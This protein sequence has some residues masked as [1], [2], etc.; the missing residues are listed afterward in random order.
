M[1][2]YVPHNMPPPPAEE[3]EDQ[4]GAGCCSAILLVAGVGPIGAGKLHL[5]FLL[6]I[7]N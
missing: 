5:K 2:R 4:V 6:S 3:P 7:V 1:A